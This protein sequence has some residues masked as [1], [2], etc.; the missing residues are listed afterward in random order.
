MGDARRMMIGSV[1]WMAHMSGAPPS[2]AAAFLSHRQGAKRR[3]IPFRFS[4]YEWWAWWQIDDRWVQRGRGKDNLVMA[5]RGDVGPYSP[6][7]VYCATTQQN[8]ADADGAARS[9]A[10]RDGLRAAMAA[11]YSPAPWAG[12]R[13]GH[14][15]AK[16]VLTPKGRF[17]SAALAAEAHGINPGTATE[18]ARRGANGWSYETG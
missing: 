17:G 4:F 15:R 1:R 7:N 12:V 8:F 16:A 5:R 13:E 14:P 11:G 2:A 6:E 18:K 9:A 10:S 3:G